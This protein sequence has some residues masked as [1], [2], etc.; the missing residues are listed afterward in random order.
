VPSKSNSD[1]GFT[2]IELLVVLIIVG[3]LAA[4]AIPVMLGQKRKAHE[5]AA[6]SDVSTIARELTDYYVDGHAPLALVPGPE[7]ATWRLEESAHVVAEGVLTRGNGVS[8]RGSIASDTSYCVAVI[9]SH[10]GAGT[11]KATQ[12]GLQP[13]DC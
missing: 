5:T 8:T 3:I 2:L 6:K 7:A 10:P 1:A 9:P 4:V 12:D 13:G 11:W